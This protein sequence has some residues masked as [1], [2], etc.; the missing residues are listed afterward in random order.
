LWL[1]SSD[2][3]ILASLVAPAAFIEHLLRFPN[4]GSISE[5][6]LQP[7][8]PLIPL[9]TLNL[10]EK[11][12]RSG[13]HVI[14]GHKTGSVYVDVTIDNNYCLA[15]GNCWSRAI[16]NS[17]TFTRGSPRIPRS[18]VSVALAIACVT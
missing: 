16:F 15:T 1:R 10:F 6:E 4:T 12:L 9:F 7:A 17:S 8:L 2:N 13:A 11:L 14:G 5:K 18:A 3:H